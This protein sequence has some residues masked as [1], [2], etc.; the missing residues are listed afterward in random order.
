MIPVSL[1]VL[2][3]I[4]VLLR[5]MPGDFTSALLGPEANPEDIARVQAEYGL[6]DNIFVQLFSYMKQLLTL[7]F[8]DSII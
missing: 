3:I 4:F 1:G 5:S 2:I 6:I 8:G 7:N